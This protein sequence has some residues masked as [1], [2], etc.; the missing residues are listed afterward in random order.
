M[1]T[2]YRMETIEI[3]FLSHPTPEHL[4]RLTMLT[5]MLEK[6][7]IFDC[8]SCFP[9]FLRICALSRHDLRIIYMATGK[10]FNGIYL[11]AHVFVK[12][13]FAFCKTSKES[14]VMILNDVCV[15]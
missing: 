2:F 4:A 15:K 8:S 9:F 11:K 14:L 12:I 7:C 1:R 13:I 3:N 5:A 6:K 10:P